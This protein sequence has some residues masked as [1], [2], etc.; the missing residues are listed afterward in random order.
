MSEEIAAVQSGI[1]AILSLNSSL[2]SNVLTVAF[3]DPDLVNVHKSNDRAAIEANLKKLRPYDGGDCSE[4]AM[5]G[6]RTA[7]ARSDNNSLLIFFSDA[8]AKDYFEAPEVTRLAKEKNVTIMFFI[9][10]C[11]K[12]CASYRFRVYKLIAYD[13]GGRLYRIR[14]IE[15][16]TVRLHL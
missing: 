2:V 14:R 5:L 7:V 13:T 8:S 3:S 10:G 11:C 4:M 6:L 15:A 16:Q 1:R 9:T 12:S